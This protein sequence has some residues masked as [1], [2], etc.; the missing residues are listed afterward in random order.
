LSCS[1]AAFDRVAILSVEGLTRA[2]IARVENVNWKTVDRWLSRATSAA[3]R[4]NHQEINGV[5]LIEIQAD[6]L[7]TF[8]PDKSRATWIFTSIEV[9]SRLWI[10]TVVGRRS[11]RNT[12]TLLNDT[13]A[14]GQ[15]VGKPLI[16]TDG[17]KY[18][19]LVVRKLF[20][21]SC[22]YAQVIKLLRKD[23]VVRVD[24]RPMI[25]TARKL[26]EALDH[27]EDSARI[28]TAFIER[29][30][31]TLRCSVAYLARR[32]PGHARSTKRLS[33]QLELLRYYYNF[34]RHHMSLRFGTETRTP[35]MQAGLSVRPYRFRE[36]FVTT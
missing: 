9:C 8:A 10:S 12:S 24:V 5:P 23:H 11:Y 36:L 28:N 20:S 27:S 18:Y 32:S 26:D 21:V 30:N 17:F 15:L 6:E 3:R 7:R 22:V 13:I 2:A 14:R 29:L 34:C 16:T 35:A 31:L 4:F 25:G 19:A 33:H 1:R